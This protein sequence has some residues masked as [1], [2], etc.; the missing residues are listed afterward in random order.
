MKYVLQYKEVMLFLKFLCFHEQ[1]WLNE[2]TDEFKP[3]YYK[4]YFDDIFVLFHLP[5]HLEKLKNHLSCKHRNIRFTCEKEHD[6][7]MRFLD[8]L[9]TRT[10]NGFKTS[11]YH[12]QTFTEV[13][14]NFNSFISKEYKVGLFFTLLFQAFSIVL[15]FSRLHLE[16]CHLKKILKT[17]AFPI[18]L[19]DSCIKNFL[20]KRLTDKPVTL[21]AER[22]DL[23]IVLTFLGKLSLDLKTRLKNSIGKTSYF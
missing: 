3:V 12:K 16:V 21:T 14:R 6:N 1:I 13:H 10:S 18:R 11:A 20:E 8:L 9:I 4:I 5:V 2:C 19:I 15:Y 17:N 7:S 23:V 22:K